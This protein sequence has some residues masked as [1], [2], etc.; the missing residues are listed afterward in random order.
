[1]TNLEFYEECGRILGVEY[2]KPTWEDRP[3][4]NRYDELVL[5]SRGRFAG[6]APGN[7]R[8]PGY[9]VI[10]VFGSTIHL[11]SHKEI[12]TFKTKES[13]L[14]YLKGLRRES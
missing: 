1:M 12:R 10:R 13:V 2:D 3:R 14:D 4:I 8:Y 5:T 9:G 11:A 6:R 7:G